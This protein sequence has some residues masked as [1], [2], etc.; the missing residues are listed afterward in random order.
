MK[1][2]EAITNSAT[3]PEPPAPIHLSLNRDRAAIR[4][5]WLLG[6]AG[7][8][9]FFFYLANANLN[10]SL[11]WKTQRLTFVVGALFFF[12]LGCIGLVVSFRAIQWLLLTFWPRR[13]YVEISPARVEMHLGPFGTN[14]YDWSRIKMSLG[15]NFEPEMLDHL[16]DDVLLPTMTHPSSTEDLL[17]RLQRFVG[18]NTEQLTGLIR[19]YLKWHWNSKA[20]S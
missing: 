16:P 2:T 15:E 13:L 10:L 1:K 8:I 14:T 4:T 7:L 17:A 18:I 19:P 11:M 3:T 6:I 20:H 9:G 12:L 5:L